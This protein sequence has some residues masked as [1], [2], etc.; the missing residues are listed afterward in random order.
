MSLIRVLGSAVLVLLLLSGAAWADPAGPIIFAGFDPEG[1][2]GKSGVSNDHN[3]FFVQQSLEALALA[4][5]TPN[6]IVGVYGA[7]DQSSYKSAFDWH[8]TIGSYNIPGDAWELLDL[9]EVTPGTTDSDGSGDRDPGIGNTDAWRTTNTDDHL[10]FFGS[11]PTDASGFS[12]IGIVVIAAGASIG[13]DEAAAL[14]S[15]WLSGGGILAFGKTDGNEF[16]WFET[17]FGAG[18]GGFGSNEQTGENNFDEDAAK[19]D[20]SDL[21]GLSGGPGAFWDGQGRNDSDDFEFDFSFT[22]GAGG[23]GIFF[24]TGAVEQRAIAFA[25]NLNAAPE[26]GSLALLAVAMGALAIRRRRRR[27]I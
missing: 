2:G 18:S 6:R 27:A 23:E 19:I 13:T 20:P 1:G 16:D 25:L 4:I 8:E 21:I 15:F 12:T 17:F 14:R 3:I 5:S 22:L 26:P 11:L 24:G 10:K 9:P 7:S